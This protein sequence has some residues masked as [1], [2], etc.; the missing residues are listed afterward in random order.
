[1]FTHEVKVTIFIPVDAEW[2]EIQAYF[3]R[4][5]AS[6]SS[7]RAKPLVSSYKVLSHRKILSGIKLDSNL[8][9]K[10]CDSTGFSIAV[11]HGY[12]SIRAE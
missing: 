4:P 11:L 6:Q 9:Y 2:V 12:Q 8:S 7:T 1:M 3:F 5:R 10:R